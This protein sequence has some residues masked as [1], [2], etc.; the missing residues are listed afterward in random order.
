MFEGVERCGYRY[1]PLSSSIRV[2]SVACSGENRKK[3][4]PALAELPGS[5]YSLVK[6]DWPVLFGTSGRVSAMRFS[7]MADA[8]ARILLASSL[9]SGW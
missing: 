3:G 5:A 8:S 9:F 6:M 2:Q 4:R 7:A 1:S